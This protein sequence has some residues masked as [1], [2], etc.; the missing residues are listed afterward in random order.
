MNPTRDAVHDQQSPSKLERAETEV[1]V[2]S[3]SVRS[4]M[5]GG[6][7]YGRADARSDPSGLLSIVAGSL[8]SGILVEVKVPDVALV[9]QYTASVEQVAARETF[10]QRQVSAFS[11][12]VER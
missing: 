6:G 7:E 2:L 12:V 8:I 4:Q 11:L 1:I 9:A 3:P 10:Q 5:A